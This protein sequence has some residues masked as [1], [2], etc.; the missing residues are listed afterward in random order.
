MLFFSSNLTVFLWDCSHL[1]TTIK[2]IFQQIDKRLMF[3]TTGY[4]S[5]YFLSYKTQDGVQNVVL[6]VCEKAV[7]SLQVIIKVKKN[8]IT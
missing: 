5:L 6:F 2:V 8:E 7:K 4:S 3:I 1:S